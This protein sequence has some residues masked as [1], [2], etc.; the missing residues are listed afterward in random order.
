MTSQT[1]PASGQAAL[2]QEEVMPGQHPHRLVRTTMTV[3]AVAVAVLLGSAAAATAAPPSPS[4]SP[5]ATSSP[6]PAPAPDVKQGTTPPKVAVCVKG[7]NGRLV[8][9]PKPVP[10]SKMPAGAKNSSTVNQPIADVAQLVDTRTWTSGGGNT[11]PGA[12]VPFGMTQWSPDTMPNRSAGGGYNFGDTSITGYSLTHV[13]GPGCGAAGDVPM[14]PMTGALPS[15]DPN[16]VITKFSNANE[17]AQAGYYSAQSSQPNTITSEFTATAHTSMG[18]FTYPATDQAGFLIKLHDSQN[19]EGA[20]STATVSGDN[21]VSG[22][23]TSGNFCGEANNDGQQQEYT[24]HFDITFDQPFTAS[25]IIMGSDGSPTA[26]YLTFDTTADPTIQAK[27]GTSYVSDANAKLDVQTENP[28]WDF[29]SVRTT[30]QQDWNNLLG[31]VQIWGG[32]Y[33]QTQEFYSLLY[34]DFMQPN[35]SS[36]VNGEY[37]GA[38][39]Q[40]HTV[41]GGQK[42]QY[43][44]YSGWDIYHSLS[45]LQAMLDPVAAGDQAQSLVNYYDQ[46]Q[47]L[48]QWGYLNLNNYVMVGDPAQSIIADYYAF[49]AHNFDTSHALKDMLTQA[50]TVND[51][52]PGEALEQKYGYLPEDGAYGCCNAHGQVPTLEEYDSNDL[53]LAQFAKAL[54]DTASASMLEKRANNWENT[55]NPANN[56]LNPR[57]TNGSFI[58]N[59][60][61]TTTDRYVEGD[62]YEYLWNT[63]NNYAALFSL[64]GGKAKVASALR[65]FLSQPNGFGMF[66]QLT[67]EFGFGEQYAGDYAGDPAG[68][69]QAVANIRSTMYAP[70]PSLDNNDDL[71]AN[72]STFIWEMLGMYPENSG[73]DNLVFNGPGFPHATITPPNGK[74]I[75]INAPAASPSTYY[76]QNLKLNGSPYEQLYV[77]YST[78]A[79]GATL[80]WT[81]GTKPSTW[82]T[83]S[84]DAPPSYGAGTEPVVGFASSAQVTLAPGGT[85]TVTIGAQNATTSTQ[86]VQAAV[87]AP[88]SLSVSPSSTTLNVP[89]SGRGTATLTL[90][91]DASTPQTFYRVPV[92]LSDGGTDLPKITLTVLVAQPGNLLRAFNNAG[93]SDDSNVNAANFDG[94]GWSYSADAMA[95]QGATPG[96]TVKAGDITYS[97]P[98]SQPGDPDNAIA[99]GQR[100]TVNAV[101]GT[102]QLGFL[103]AASGGASQGLTTL[104]Y[105]DGST[106]RYWLGLSDWT[107]G[108]GTNTPSFGNQTVVTTAYRNCNHC[109]GGRDNVKTNVFSTILP[110][111]PSKTLSSVTLPSGTTGGELHVFA[112][113]TSTA[114]PSGPVIASLDPNTANAGDTVT[115][116]GGGFGA[117]QGNGY[118]AFSDNNIDWGPPGNLAT[119]HV[120]SWSDTQITFTVPTPSGAS[121]QWHVAP[122][123]TAMVTVVNDAGQMSDTAAL[124]IAASANLADYYDNTGIS[125]DGDTSCQADFDGDG[126]SYSTQALAAAGVDASSTVTVDGLNYIWPGAQPCQPDNILAAGQK[127]LVH[128]ASG[129]TKLGFLG[130]SGNGSAQGPVTVT[131]ADGTSQTSQLYFGDWAQAASNGN[132]TAITT[133]YRN[134]QGSTQQITMYVFA[135]EIPIDSSKTVASV[136]L[137]SIADHVS[138]N[139]STHIFTLTT[140]S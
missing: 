18:R 37:M 104:T 131:Y 2:A 34:K 84:Q 94:G 106:A 40:V 71:G 118:V 137:P 82:G 23:E 130:S 65:T 133:P 35:I 138:S 139:T 112:I 89:P 44:T 66:A 93:I 70:G 92:S 121:G 105:S 91:A 43:G 7:P 24:V 39:M 19:G 108:G 98:L 49:G 85:A 25:Q 135:E 100:V 5:T 111:D 36:D 30:A 96:S 28:G 125:S 13:S 20:P 10:G 14:L 109:S 46:D 56:L 103:G 77:P 1:H 73:S 54:G 57:N 11:F 41:T 95:A 102:R 69:Q 12:D 115:I 48:Q 64:L 90:H 47:I 9:C 127:I 134:H 8:D 99:S 101:A 116:H 81:L 60:T 51:V 136:T 113:G 120:D 58:P 61:G 114:A 29:G 67:N 132:I 124:D 33:A 110:V 87:A 53:A 72:S 88:S 74:T 97:W 50:T 38:D 31:E 21:E 15:G 83:A 16:S 76:V 32:D 52:R 27:V 6:S 107:L 128:G 140:G 59:V 55:F 117:S 80:D 42:N 123:S 22:S 78:L 3:A 17:V 122:G 26:V 62:A 119:F 126:Y 75:T 63:P 129:A 79:K 4:P 68:T 45:Q 86:K